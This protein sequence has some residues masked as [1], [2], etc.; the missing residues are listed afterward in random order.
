MSY[1]NKYITQEKRTVFNT[2]L[3]FNKTNTVFVTRYTPD[4][5]F[6]VSWNGRTR[7]IFDNNQFQNNFISFSILVISFVSNSNRYL[8]INVSTLRQYEI[9][10]NTD[11]YYFGIFSVFSLTC[12]K[13]VFLQRI[14]R[15]TIIFFSRAKA[16][17]IRI[18]SG[19]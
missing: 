19:R 18:G 8:Y 9:I 14:S 2:R 10:Y 7:S 12:W 16:S 1:N 6:P 13:R 11:I 17:M 5:K 3:A 15:L 4:V